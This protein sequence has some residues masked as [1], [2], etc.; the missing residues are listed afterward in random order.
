[1]GHN[2]ADGSDGMTSVDALRT[3][4]RALLGGDGVRPSTKVYAGASQDGRTCGLCRVTIPKAVIEYEVTLSDGV[5]LYLDRRC[6][7]VWT[8]EAID[9]AP[10]P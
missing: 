10:S 2:G 7:N 3:R 8:Q 6:W 5:V 4:I 9:G 1:V